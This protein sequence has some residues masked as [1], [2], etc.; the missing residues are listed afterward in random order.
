MF[1]NQMNSIKKLHRKSV[2]GGG[3]KCDAY[4]KEER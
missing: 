3:Q 2:T 4:F 1:Q